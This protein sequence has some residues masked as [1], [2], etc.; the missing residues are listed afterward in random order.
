MKEREVIKMDRSIAKLPRFDSRT[1]VWQI[2]H[3]LQLSTADDP[4][5]QD[6]KQHHLIAH[7]FVGQEFRQGQPLLHVMSAKSPACGCIQLVAALGWQVQDGLTHRT[8]PPY[9]CQLAR[10]G[11]PHGPSPYCPWNHMVSVSSRTAWTSLHGSWYYRSENIH[12]KASPGLSRNCITFIAFYW[13]K[14]VT[15]HCYSRR[16]MDFT[17]W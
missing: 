2:I 9:S 11:S 1:Y 13:P 15:D 5:T 8:R 17:S 14:Q 16:E 3:L 6:W 4:N 7:H 12:C 10:C